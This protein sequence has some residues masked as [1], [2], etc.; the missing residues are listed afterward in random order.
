MGTTT[1]GD[2]FAL[3]RPALTRLHTEFGG[4]IRF[5]MIGVTQADD[6]PSWVNRS[7]PGGVAGQSY[8]GFV[9][10]ITRMP[11][12]DIGI[13]PLAD[14]AFNR[15]KSAIKTLDYAALGL[16]VLASDMEAY[17]P[18]PGGRLVANTDVDWADALG[19]LIRHP[20]LRRDMAEAARAVL[21]GSGTLAAQAGARLAA[22]R[23]V[24]TRPAPRSRPK[25]SA[26]PP[27]AAMNRR[28]APTR[29]PPA[30]G[31]RGA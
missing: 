23:E 12:W 19:H 29:L 18:L 10:W 30:P 7:L 26:S 3:V 2:D 9:N 16:A 11:A 8:P 20:N 6:L 13:A 17:R 14:T 24:L 31:D 21:L 4:R 22:W 25:P 1:H 5:D 27:P 15:A 28:G